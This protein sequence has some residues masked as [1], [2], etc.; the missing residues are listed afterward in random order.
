MINVWK[1]DPLKHKRLWGIIHM[2]ELAELKNKWNL[3]YDFTW[4]DVFDRTNITARS[5]PDILPQ[6]HHSDYDPY[7]IEKLTETHYNV[8]IN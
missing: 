8:P 6:L 4:D 1:Q 3:K 7:R 5:K 2:D